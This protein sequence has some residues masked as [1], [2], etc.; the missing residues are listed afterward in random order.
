MMEK[1]KNQV[2]SPPSLGAWIEMEMALYINTILLSPP[3]L[4]AW[5]EIELKDLL[6]KVVLVAPFT[7]G[8]D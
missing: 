1:L 8:V 7:G 6:R 3:S 2:K 4:G 5:I